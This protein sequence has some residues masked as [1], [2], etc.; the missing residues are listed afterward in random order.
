[1][2]TVSMLVILRVV[3]V[4]SLSVGALSHAHAQVSDWH[5]QRALGEIAR[6]SAVLDQVPTRFDECSLVEVL[7]DSAVNPLCQYE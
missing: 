3:L 1:M 7:G 6:T 2:I 4:V 5:T